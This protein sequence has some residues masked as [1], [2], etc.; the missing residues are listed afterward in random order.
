MVALIQQILICLCVYVTI[1]L[2]CW[3]WRR[4]RASLCHACFMQHRSSNPSVHYN[5]N[6]CWQS[7]GHG[8]NQG[9][10]FPASI[11]GKARYFFLPPLSNMLFQRHH[12]KFFFLFQHLEC[13]WCALIKRKFCASRCWILLLMLYPLSIFFMFLKWACLM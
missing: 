6:G 13:V 3:Y 11:S 4:H 9:D 8:Y 1:G 10:R 2:D 7:Q 5:L 12:T